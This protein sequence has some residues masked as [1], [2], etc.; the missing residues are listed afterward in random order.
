MKIHKIICIYFCFTLVIAQQE[1]EIKTPIFQWEYFTGTSNALIQRV[2][3]QW[4]KNRQKEQMIEIVSIAKEPYSISFIEEILLRRY[5]STDFVTADYVIT[6]TSSDEKLIFTVT[7]V[8]IYLHDIITD[9]AV[10]KYELYEIKK[11]LKDASKNLAEQIILSEKKFLEKL[12][13]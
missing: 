8:N 2:S 5:K 7:D 10:K 9:A 12:D 13:K 6:I 11:S 1:K 3:L 4:L